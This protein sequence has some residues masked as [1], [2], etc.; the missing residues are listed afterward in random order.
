[1]CYI[2]IEK[3]VIKVLKEV[4]KSILILLKNSTRLVI[5]E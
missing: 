2:I 1:M 5:C 3:Q 4:V